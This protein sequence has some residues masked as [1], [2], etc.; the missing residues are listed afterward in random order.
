MAAYGSEQGF[1]AWLTAQGLEL[2]PGAPA[3]AVLMQIGSSY[4]DAAYEP[5]LQC[6][7][8]AEGFSQELAWPR[9]GHWINGQLVPEDLIPPAW[10][11]ASYRAAYL[12]A[13][14]PG[15]ATGSVDPNRV[16]KREKV[17]VIEREFF[18]TGDSGSAASASGMAA[19]ALLN[20]MVLPWLCSGAR[21]ANSL[22]RVI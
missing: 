19:D 10:I 20:G 6:S 12:Q 15:W 16:T 7:V 14:T 5:K 3:A 2:P 21:R 17:D 1:T 9:K 22:F 4:L 13:I 8:R 18:A 11:Q